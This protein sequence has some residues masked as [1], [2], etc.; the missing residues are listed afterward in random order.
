MSHIVY[1]TLR[2]MCHICEQ[3]HYRLSYEEMTNTKV[4]DLDELFN[5]DI[6]HFFQLKLFGV[7]KSCLK[8]HFFEIQILNRSNFSYVYIDKTNKIN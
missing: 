6:Y 2:E 4:V 8:L 3:C 1:K 5:F 7:L